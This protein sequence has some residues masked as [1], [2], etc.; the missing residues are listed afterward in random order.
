MIAVVGGIAITVQGQ[1]MGVIDRQLGTLESVFLTYALG[2]AIVSLLVLAVRGGNLGQWQQLP[3]WT[4][5]SGLVGLVIVSSIGFSVAR[6]GAV[7]AFT[8]IIASQC[9]I[10][11]LID[12]FGLFGAEVRAINWQK[13]A[14]IATLLFGVWL[15]IR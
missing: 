13:L 10:A 5:T 9:V 12:H 15:T 8:L 2:T 7:S 1:M 14:G 11:A 6:L 4:L 3:W